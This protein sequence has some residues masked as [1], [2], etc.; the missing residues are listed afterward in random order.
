MTDEAIPGA[1]SSLPEQIARWGVNFRLRHI[2]V[3][4]VVV[5][6]LALLIPWPSLYVA[7]AV[8]VLILLLAVVSYNGATI[9]GWLRRVARYQWFRLNTAARA[10]RARIDEAKD[11]ELPGIGRMG[12]R[13]DGEHV[14]TVLALHGRAY[15]PTILA[16]DGAKTVD[17]VPLHLIGDLMRQFGGL[18]LAAV[19]VVSSGRRASGAQY[20]ATYDEIVAD[21]PAVALRETF[22]VLRL[23]PLAC[24]SAMAYRKSVQE[25]AAAATERIR[26]A[27]VSAGCRA[28]ALTADEFG[29]ATKALAG[30]ILTSEGD[31]GEVV[32]HWDHV[33]APGGYVTCYRIAGKDLDTELVNDI[34]AIQ[35]TLTV[36]TVRVELSSSG[37]VLLSGLARFHSV[38]PWPHPPQPELQPVHGQAFDALVSSLPLGDRSMR[39]QLSRRPAL[40]EH[41]EQLAPGH[42]AIELP[43]NPAGFWVGTT[44]DFGYPMLMPWTDALRPTRV[45]IVDTELEMIERLVLR[46]TAAGARVLVYTDRPDQWAPVCRDFIDLVVPGQDPRF[47]PTTLVLDT[48]NTEAIHSVPRAGQTVVTIGDAPAPE[49]DVLIRQM[50]EQVQIDTPDLPGIRLK[51][52]RP[53]NESQYVAHLQAVAHGGR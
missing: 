31:L 51:L 39:V 29:G 33:E 14:V 44:A 16:P 49:T 2:I 24:L 42:E 37:E 17:M 1:T 48:G 52:M 50:G 6:A 12:V 13:W 15:A 18:E 30:G 21:R 34:W 53:R 46:A 7:A 27:I 32:E 45:S 35:S 22:V 40:G 25:A 5:A 26:Q 3:T 8:A 28:L 10:R 9:A 19:D 36:L 43:M 20:S 41:G 11:V 23:C 4:E 38:A 47:R